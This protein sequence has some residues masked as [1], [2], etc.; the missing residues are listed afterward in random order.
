MFVQACVMLSGSCLLS[1][2]CLVF[3][4]HRYDLNQPA[5]GQRAPDDPGGI[6]DEREDRE[7]TPPPEQPHHGKRPPAD[8][9]CSGQGSPPAPFFCFTKPMTG[10]STETDEKPCPLT[11][12][13]WI[14]LLAAESQAKSGH[15]LEYQPVNS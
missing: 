10:N 1:L 13:E 15:C 12:S 11:V 9:A 5:G 7:S 4:F 8:D 14:A 6:C 3:C 2:A